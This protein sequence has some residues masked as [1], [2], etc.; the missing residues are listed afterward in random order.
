MASSEVQVHPLGPEKNEQVGVKFIL[1][2]PRQSMGCAWIDLQGHV[3]DEFG[4]G[5]SRGANR[6][7]LVVVAVND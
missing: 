1:V 3:L 5:V 4:R 6:H 2:R 7:D